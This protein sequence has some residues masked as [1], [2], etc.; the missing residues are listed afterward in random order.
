M[1][2]RVLLPIKNINF[3]PEK[4]LDK[5]IPRV[6]NSSR[7]QE[8]CAH[9]SADRVPGYEPVGRRFK[10]CW[11]R[12]EKSLFCLPRQ[13]RF[14]PAFRAKNKQIY[15]ISGFG[16]VDRLLRSPIFCVQRRK[17][18]Q[19][20]GVLFAV[21]CRCKERLKRTEGTDLNQLFTKNIHSS[22]DLITLKC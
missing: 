14:F 17:R 21:L 13:E 2:W 7:I 16:A 10:S 20:A 9:S 6:Y 19:N 12:H 1:A 15:A 5:G 18:S 4:K 22:K 3:F 8:M 11:A